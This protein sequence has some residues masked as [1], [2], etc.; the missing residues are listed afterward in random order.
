MLENEMSRALLLANGKTVG[1]QRNSVTIM[2]YDC[3][4]CHILQVSKK[5]ALNTT[6]PTQQVNNKI[7]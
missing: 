6:T 3:L 1:K 5:M 7:R 4:R 2:Y